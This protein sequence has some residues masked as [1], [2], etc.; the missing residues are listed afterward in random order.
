MR[1]SNHRGTEGTEERDTENKESKSLSLP[2][3]PSVPLWFNLSHE[4]RD[5]LAV[6]EV[7]AEVLPREMLELPSYG[8]REPEK[9]T[10]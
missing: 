10:G 4:S 8:D 1:D 3:V 9:L 5:K 2:S 6:S 7:L